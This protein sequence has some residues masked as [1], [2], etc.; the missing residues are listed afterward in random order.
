MFCINCG[1]QILDT[2]RFCNYC[3]TKVVGFDENIQQSPA[4]IPENPL[5]IPAEDANFS[6]N[7]ENS[8]DLLKMQNDASSA[9]PQMNELSEDGNTLFSEKETPSSDIQSGAVG[10]QHSADVPDQDMDI[11]I[12]PIPEQSASIT[13]SVGQPISPT[14]EQPPTGTP[15]EQSAPASRTFERPERRYTIGHIVMCLASTALMA[16][17]AGVF[18]GLYFSVV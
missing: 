3:G 11:P 14:S 4:K 16:I 17:A 6:E 12:S 5:P 13:R 1:K 9:E 18:A 8:V 7:V 15:L 10:A 2:A